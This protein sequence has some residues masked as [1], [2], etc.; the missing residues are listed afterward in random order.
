M[1]APDGKTDTITVGM[2]VL[3]ET[4]K[5]TLPAELVA[6]KMAIIKAIS[7]AT[8]QRAT[9][10]KRR[11]GDGPKPRTINLDKDGE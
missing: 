1:I 4:P 6:D 5:E 8:P 7:I 10:Q 9:K 2:D 11:Q 3:E